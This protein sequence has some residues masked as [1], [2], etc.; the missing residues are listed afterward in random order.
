MVKKA[1]DLPVNTVHHETSYGRHRTLHR[2]LLLPCGF[3]PSPDISNPTPIKSS[4]PRTRQNPG[5]QLSEEDYLF[6][7]SDVDHWWYDDDSQYMET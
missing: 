5:P 7:N 6:L 4:R 3:L 2:D 1:G